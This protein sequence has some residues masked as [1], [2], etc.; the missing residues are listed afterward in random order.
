MNLNGMSQH[1]LVENGDEYAQKKV[2][3]K[4]RDNDAN[5]ASKRRCISTACIACRR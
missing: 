4:G 1:A 5:A 3:N 2:K